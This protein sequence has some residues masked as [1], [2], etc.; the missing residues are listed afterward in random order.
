M[1]VHIEKLYI[2][3]GCCRKMGIVSTIQFENFCNKVTIYVNCSWTIVVN[4]H[5]SPRIYVYKCLRE[6]LESVQLDHYVAYS[7][8]ATTKIWTGR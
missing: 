1:H 4:Q 2:Q 8:E 5:A 6:M 3:N 7:Q